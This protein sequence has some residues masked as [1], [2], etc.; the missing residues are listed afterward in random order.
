MTT[1]K[2]E[3]A[4]E[5]SGATGFKKHE[6]LKMADA[7]FRAM[8]QSLTDGNRIEIRG[9]G[10]LDVKDAKAKPAARNPGTGEVTNNCLLRS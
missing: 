4:L 5:V 8:L 7:L 9:F 2:K 10:V 3:L 1:T 6:S